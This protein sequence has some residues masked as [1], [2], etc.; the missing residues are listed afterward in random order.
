MS[1][2]FARLAKEIYGY[3]NVKYM[4]EG[5]MTWE[6]GI[7][8]YYTEPDFLKMAID[9]GLSYVLIDLRG[10]GKRPVNRISREQ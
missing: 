10:S 1:P 7:N 8:P 3:K 4:V 2:H 5:H 6:E 9:E